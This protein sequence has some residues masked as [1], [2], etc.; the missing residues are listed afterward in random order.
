MDGVNSLNK[1]YDYNDTN[2]G[3]QDFENFKPPDLELNPCLSDNHETFKSDQCDDNIHLEE[4]SIQDS[5]I[6]EVSSVRNEKVVG[7]EDDINGKACIGI[8]GGTVTS[9]NSLGDSFE[10]QQNNILNTQQYQDNC[11][12]NL[13]IETLNPPSINTGVGNTL[14]R[15]NTLN[16]CTSSNVESS[17]GLNFFDT[18]KMVANEEYSGNSSNKELLELNDSKNLQVVKPDLKQSEVSLGNINFLSNQKFDSCVDSSSIE[19]S[20]VDV[21]VDSSLNSLPLA[22]KVES[23]NNA[24]LA[25]LQAYESD[26]EESANEA[27]N[28]VILEYREDKNQVI[29]SDEESDSDSSSTCSASKIISETER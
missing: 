4:C 12:L 8:K 18:G 13:S 26:G 27:S 20:L 6:H 3:D 28:V 9:D 7:K 2:S 14:L 17:N 1:H 19:I 10:H 16:E 24:S 29:E 25:Q 22:G 5:G 15:T 11:T 23:N 21:S